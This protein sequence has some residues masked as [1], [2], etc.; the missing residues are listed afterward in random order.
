MVHGDDKNPARL[1]FDM[2]RSLPDWTLILLLLLLVIQ[3]LLLLLLLLPFMLLLLLLLLNYLHLLH[4]LHLLL[5]YLHLLLHYLHLLPPLRPEVTTGWLTRKNHFDSVCTVK[6]INSHC[7][8]RV[9]TKPRKKGCFTVLVISVNKETNFSI[10][11][12]LYYV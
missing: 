2:T 3:L 9:K 11:S 10:H 1:N 5:H 8:A 4:Y 12:L 6:T 7:L